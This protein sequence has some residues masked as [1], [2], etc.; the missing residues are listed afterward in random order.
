MPFGR[1]TGHVNA[2]AGFGPWPEGRRL[3]GEL[4]MSWKVRPKR[5]RD[6]TRVRIPFAT[7]PSRR[8]GAVFTTPPQGVAQL[9]ACSRVRIPL[10]CVQSDDIEGSLACS[11]RPSSWA[12]CQSRRRQ[13]YNLDYGRDDQIAAAGTVVGLFMAAGIAYGDV[14]REEID[15]W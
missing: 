3:H 10:A 4:T 14:V 5:D 9:P 2:D 7:P 13:R 8:A 11:R 1:R 15:T 6:K 12:A